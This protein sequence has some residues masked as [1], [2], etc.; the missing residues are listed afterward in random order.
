MHLRESFSQLLRIDTCIRRAC[1][2]SATIFK[3]YSDSSLSL[4]RT[5]ALGFELV[6][7][8]KCDTEHMVARIC[9][10]LCSL[11]VHVLSL[12]RDHY[13]ST[14]LSVYFIWRLSSVK[15]RVRQQRRCLTLVHAPL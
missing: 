4:S 3:P 10:C 6:R 8:Q 7:K 13:R 5:Q 2:A 9:F 14:V 11:A 12:E 1:D 15:H